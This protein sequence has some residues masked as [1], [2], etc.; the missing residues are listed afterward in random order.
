MSKN[1]VSI[2]RKFIGLIIITIIVAIGLS[3]YFNY[4]QLF[5]DKTTQSSVEETEVM[6]DAKLSIHYIDVGQGDSVFI[7]LPDSTCMLIDAGIKSKG[8]VVSQYVSGLGY[9]VID[10]LIVTHGDTDHVGGIQTVLDNFEVKNIYRPYQISLDSEG[11]VNPDDDLKA[12]YE[13]ATVKSNINVI[14]NT[15]YYN[16]ISKAYSETYTENS[17]VKQ[18]IVSTTYDGLK[19]M[20]KNGYDFSIEFFGPLKTLNAETLIDS[21]LATVTNGYPTLYYGSTDAEK[22]NSAS[23]I[24]LLEYA[25]GS[26]LFTGDAT[27]DTEQDVINSLTNDEKQR[28]TKVD[29]LHV[30]HHGSKTSSSAEFL[31]VVQPKMSIISVGAGNRYN[32]P[33]EE[34]LSR[35]EEYSGENIFRTDTDGNIV[36]LA[37]AENIQIKTNNIVGTVSDR[38]IYLSPT[39]Y[40]YVY[41]IAITL[42]VFI[43]GVIYIYKGKSGL[44]KYKK[45]KSYR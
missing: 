42:F 35:L 18:A 33:T 6:T 24:M 11:N 30:G 12:V 36:I 9:G 4:N 38:E 13:Q 19:I 27:E 29:V 41:V 28:I 23:P 40:W 25:E 3:L 21:G 7:E 26:Y 31:T 37:N 1:K 44:K 8:E 14:D 15:A 2:K 45:G 34:A 5:G 20:P 10:Y 17:I 43:S 22:K 16:F 32:H 39:R